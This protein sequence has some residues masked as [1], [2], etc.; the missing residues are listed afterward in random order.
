[1]REFDGYASND[2]TRKKLAF[3]V[4]SKGDCYFLTGKFF[5]VAKLFI[6]IRVHLTD[7]CTE[8]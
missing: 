2:A 7:S 3:D 6:L 8:A 4:F 1:M 5:C